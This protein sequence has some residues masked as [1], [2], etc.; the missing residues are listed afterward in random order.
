M[1]LPLLL[2]MLVLLMALHLTFTEIVQVQQVVI[3]LDKLHTLVKTV[4]AVKKFM[5]KLQVR[6][7]TLH[8]TLKMDLSKLLLKETVLS[9]LLVD[10]NQ[11]NYNF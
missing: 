11:T 3:I 5:Q 7:L 4:M 9:L 6:L 10:K 1:I 8:I 2:L